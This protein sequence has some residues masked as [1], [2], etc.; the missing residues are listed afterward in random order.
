[1]AAEVD[2]ERGV[3]SGA[4]RL[5]NE[6]GLIYKVLGRETAQV[7]AQVRAFWEIVREGGRRSDRSAVL[8]LAVNDASRS[9]QRLCAFDKI[10]E[11]GDEAAL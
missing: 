4:C 5:P 11:G 1:M 6:A 2:L 9:P 3:A 10:R 8:S 7:K